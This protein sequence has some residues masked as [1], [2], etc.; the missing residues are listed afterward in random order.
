MKREKVWLNVI[1]WRILL[2]YWSNVNYIDAIKLTP[3]PQKCPFFYNANYMSCGSQTWEV[4]PSCRYIVWGKVFI[5]DD[6]ICP[7]LLFLF[8]QVPTHYD[9]EIKFSYPFLLH[10]IFFSVSPFLASH[11][12]LLQSILKVHSPMLKEISDMKK[13]GNPSGHF[14]SHA[15]LQQ[16]SPIRKGTPQQWQH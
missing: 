6:L 4:Y 13:W 8:P 11:F 9:V 12:F 2:D 14:K 5:K 7:N 16:S 1:K 3:A 10:S 15:C